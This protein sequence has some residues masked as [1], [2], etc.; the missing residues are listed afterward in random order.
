MQERTRNL[1]GGL[2]CMARSPHRPTAPPPP[3]R[4]TA[5]PRDRP[6]DCPVGS[7]EKLGC[8]VISG[9]DWLVVCG[10]DRLK[11]AQVDI[12]SNHFHSKHFHSYAHHFAIVSAS[13]CP[14]AP[15]VHRV[16]CEQDACASSA[17]WSA[18]VSGGP[19]CSGYASSTEQ[20][21]SHEAT[22]WLG[23]CTHLVR[24]QQLL[25]G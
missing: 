24:L 25:G 17:V 12:H 21:G 20:E 8:L 13:C 1:C 23:A 16:Q 3:D 6:T 22:S 14:P 18:E 11:L 10:A 9:A 2:L 4:P 19:A 7:F 5:R 15:S